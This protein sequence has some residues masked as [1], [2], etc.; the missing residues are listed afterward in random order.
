MG[1]ITDRT[2]PPD[3]P[4]TNA[5][6]SIEDPDAVVPHEMRLGQNVLLMLDEPPRLGET[7]NIV[8]RLR[9]N[10]IGEEQPAVDGEIRYFCGNTIVTAWELGKP[11]P[12]DPDQE[13]PAL[14]GED[15]EVSADAGDDE[16]DDLVGGDPELDD[17]AC[18]RPPFSDG[19]V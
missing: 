5:L 11:K 13:Q 15:G 7:R 16:D 18:G 10:R 3:V 9:C 12:P 17:E 6:A 19:A 2:A 1:I 14:F 8:V 4:T